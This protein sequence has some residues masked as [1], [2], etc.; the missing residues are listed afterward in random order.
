MCHNIKLME[1]FT[2]YV[3]NSQ[4]MSWSHRSTMMGMYFQTT[5]R[6]KTKPKLLLESIFISFLFSPKAP[7]QL[8]C[9][10]SEITNQT[11]INSQKN[12]NPKYT[13][14]KN[15]Q[16]YQLWIRTP[17]D[18]SKQRTG[19]NL[20]FSKNRCLG[21]YFKCKFYSVKQLQILTHMAKFVQ[22][23]SQVHQSL[24]ILSRNQ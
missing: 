6:T 20:L 12:L 17:Q 13:S 1:S 4:H 24:S 7:S 21:F 8:S 23:S 3:L 22:N 11:K 2:G 14:L 18:C 16:E 15:S 10:F 5:C 19:V 9:I